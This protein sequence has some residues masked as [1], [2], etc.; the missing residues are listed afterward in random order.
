MRRAAAPAVARVLPLAAAL[1]LAGCGGERSA[2]LTDPEGGTEV[3]MVLRAMVGLHSDWRR[4]VVVTAP[5]GASRTVDLLAD[6]GW[7]RGSQ[8]WRGPDGGLALDEGQAGCVAL[9]GRAP[10]GP[11][12]TYLGRFEERDGV[13]AVPPSEAG[14]VRLPDPL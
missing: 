12:S 11:P 3:R 10:C 7:W 4:R 13:A 2:A 8:L 9:V 14:P 6:T 1:A 5:D